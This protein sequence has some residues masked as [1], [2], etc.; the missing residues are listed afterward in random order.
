M[1]GLQHLALST[2][3][4]TFAERLLLR[5]PDWEPF[6]T[7]YTR[8]HAGDTTAPGSLWM[9]VPSS[10]DPAAPLWAF[11]QE[12]EVLVGLGHRAAEALFP[13]EPTEQ[14]EAIDEALNFIDDVATAEVVG[15]WERHRLLWLTWETCQFRRAADVIQ[16]RKV[17]RVSAWP[18][19][20][21]QRRAAAT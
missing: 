13:W 14:D 12:E 9:E 1:S 4:R 8:V 19:T 7:Q 16:D 2:A 5:H 11:V 18:P 3:A 17:V 15:A 6:I 20:T 21:G 10:G